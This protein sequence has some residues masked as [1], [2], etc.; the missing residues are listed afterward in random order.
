M[1]LHVF[2][3]LSPS[4]DWPTGRSQVWWSIQD[5]LREILSRMTQSITINGDIGEYPQKRKVSKINHDCECDEFEAIQRIVKHYY[6]IAL[7]RDGALRGVIRPGFSPAV[8]HIKETSDNEILLVV[9]MKQPRRAIKTL[10]N[11]TSRGPQTP[12][13]KELIEASKISWD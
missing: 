6:T 4:P 11:I 8:K 5:S 12:S 3:C 7:K 10:H 2:A 1:W 9:R 13:L